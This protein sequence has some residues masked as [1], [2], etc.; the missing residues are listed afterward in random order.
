M[1]FSVML[2]S[3]SED[4][5]KGST[6]APAR[7]LTVY[8]TPLM[9]FTSVKEMGKSTVYALLKLYMRNLGPPFW[10]EMLSLLMS[11]DQVVKLYLDDKLRRRAMTEVELGSVE[12]VIVAPEL[13]YTKVVVAGYRNRIEVAFTTA[14]EDEYVVVSENAPEFNERL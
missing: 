13:L 10:G 11:N 7:M 4:T 2:V 8:V 9:H 5:P 12:D 3:T 14:L 1:N 6:T